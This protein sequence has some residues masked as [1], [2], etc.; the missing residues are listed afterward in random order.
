MILY[1]SYVYLDKFDLWTAIL[2]PINLFS[3]KV[4]KFFLFITAIHL[5]LCFLV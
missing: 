4:D 2:K 1:S 3:V 5:K